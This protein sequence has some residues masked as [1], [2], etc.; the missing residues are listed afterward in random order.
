MVTLRGMLPVGTASLCSCQPQYSI[1]S[2]TNRDRAPTYNYQRWGIGSSRT[3][4]RDRINPFSVPDTKQSHENRSLVVKQ[5]R[6]QEEKE[7][8]Y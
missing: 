5:Y 8:E 4:M 7:D 6:Q 2:A 3:E 1:F